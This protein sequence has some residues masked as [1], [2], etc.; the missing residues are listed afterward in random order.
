MEKILL[1]FIGTLDHS[2][3]KQQSAGFSHLTI[4]QFQYIDAIAALGSPTLSEVAARLGF[5]KA[6]AT[7]ALNK[8]A[9]LGFIAK[10]QSVSDKRV[11]H[12]SLTES[13]RQL[14]E[15]KAQSIKT[16]VEF[17]ASALNEDEIRQFEVILSKLTAQFRS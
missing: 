8:L 9:V 13:G 10:T 11:F 2:L 16:Y 7:T 4:S 6:S 14:A 1:E 15:A 5:S 17:I 12:V 3:K